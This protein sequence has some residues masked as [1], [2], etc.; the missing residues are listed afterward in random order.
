MKIIDEQENHDVSESITTGNQ[1]VQHGT[2]T[3]L[4]TGHETGPDNLE[5]EDVSNVYLEI[6]DDEPKTGMGDI[7]SG[8]AK[9]ECNNTGDSSD[10]YDQ[11]LPDVSINIIM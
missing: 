6:V 8:M 2:D 5:Y 9:G 3:A 10:D 7:I 11:T 1:S 4:S